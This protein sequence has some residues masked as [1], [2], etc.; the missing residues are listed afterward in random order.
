MRTAAFLVDILL[1]YS[2]HLTAVHAVYNRTFSEVDVMPFV[3][4]TVSPT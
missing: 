4:L 3:S 1:S 2:G